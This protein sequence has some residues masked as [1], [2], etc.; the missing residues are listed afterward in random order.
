MTKIYFEAP[1]AE[2]V[3][4]YAGFGAYIGICKICGKETDVGD[5]N[6]CT[7]C[8]VKA[9]T[10]KVCIECLHNT[11]IHCGGTDFKLNDENICLACEDEHSWYEGVD[12]KDMS[13]KS[14]IL[15]REKKVLNSSNIC[16]S[17]YYNKSNI[18]HCIDCGKSYIEEDDGILCQNCQHYC[19]SCG[20]QF[21]QNARDDK[22]CRNCASDISKGICTE[23]GDYDI[24]L[25]VYGK[26]SKHS[27]KWEIDD[28]HF[29]CICN[30]VEV[31]NPRDVCIK[32]SVLKDDCA[33]G[34]EKSVIQYQCPNCLVNRMYR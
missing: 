6:I 15:C 3:E 24:A 1:I 28:R 7:P 10:K 17:C 16:E 27:K 13:P 29:C 23:C 14:C 31:N 18:K 32:C 25:D 9:L 33:C 8:T 34:A 12:K 22:Y 19:I 4:E 20:T 5:A 30:T 26:C 21:A 2:K 11:C